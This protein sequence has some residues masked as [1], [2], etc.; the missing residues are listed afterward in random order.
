MSSSLSLNPRL[1]VITG[2]L[3]GTTFALQTGEVSIGRDS[4]NTVR[5][6]HPSVSRHHCLIKCAGEQCTV[7][8]LESYNG[9]FV[10]GLPIK[11]QD[12]SHADQIEVGDIRLLFL[13]RESEESRELVELSDTKIISQ[14]TMQ[15]RREEALFLRPDE[16]LQRAPQQARV[17]RDLGVL[18]RISS[19][20]NKLRRTA[21]LREE[22]LDSIFAVVPAERGA[23]LLTDINGELTSVQGRRRQDHGKTMSVSR[24]VVKQVV[25]DAVFILSNDVRTSETLAKAESLVTARTASLMCAPLIVFEKVIGAIYLDTSDAVTRF[26][27]GHLQL[28]AGIAGIAALALE[29]ARETEWLEDENLRLRSS[30]EIEHNMIGQSLAMREVYRKIARVAGAD[31]TVLIQGESGTGKELAARAIHANSPRA[32]KPFIPVNCAALTETLLES[33]LFGH[34]KGAFTG[35]IAQKKGKFEI[36][37]SGTVF[38]DEIGEMAAPLQARLLRFLQDHKIERVGGTRSIDLDVRVVAATNRNLDQAIAAGM[39]RSDLFHRLNVVTLTMPSLRHRREDIPLLASYFVTKYAKACKRPVTGISPAARTLLQSYDWPGNVREL[40][41][42]IERAVVMGSTESIV[43][44]DLPERI[45]ET[46]REAQ[47]PA[48]KNYEAIKQAKRELILRALAETK[49]NYTEAAKQL[50]VHPNNLHR[51]IRS[52]DLKKAINKYAFEP[53]AVESQHTV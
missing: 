42:A 11:E 32:A 8:D 39:F 22:I 34:E 15:L 45:L 36:A 24:T 17:A 41:N 9:T 25:K 35:A 26:D 10:N 43:I 4:D 46:A 5:L 38:L 47:M 2:S 31:S 40:E 52:L 23:I 1:I 49:G 20:V 18:L 29:N 33:E 44:D 53:S 27:E 48:A 16:V 51:L 13:T 30:L 12:L 50:G 37:Q 6:N 19:R 21:E 28:L 3:R 14:S 7:S